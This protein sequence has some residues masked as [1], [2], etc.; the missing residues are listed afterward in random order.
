LPAHVLN[1]M[2]K[3]HLKSAAIPEIPAKA[4]VTEPEGT[5]PT[6]KTPA[7]LGSSGYRLSPASVPIGTEGHRIKGKRGPPQSACYGHATGGLSAYYPGRISTVTVARNVS[8]GPKFFNDF[9]R[10]HA[11]RARG[12]ASP[13]EC[14]PGGRYS[15]M[16]GHHRPFNSSSGGRRRRIG[17]MGIDN[18][19]RPATNNNRAAARL[20][21]R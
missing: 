20:A 12:G 3:M 19:R 7:R 13:T 16:V 1:S 5:W 11:Q 4:R 18:S 10:A 17:R 2:V 14:G 6:A 15:A 9:S 21:R 8:M